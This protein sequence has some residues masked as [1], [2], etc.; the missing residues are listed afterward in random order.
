MKRLLF[1]LLLA[2]LPA[3]AA[4]FYLEP[5]VYAVGVWRSVVPQQITITLA[6]TPASDRRFL[7]GFPLSNTATP[8]L[9]LPPG[10]GAICSGGACNSAAFDVAAG[11]SCDIHYDSWPKDANGRIGVK[12]VGCGDLNTAG[13]ITSLANAVTWQSSQTGTGQEEG[14][15]CVQGSAGPGP[16]MWRG[17]DSFMSGNEFH[18]ADFRKGAVKKQMWFYRNRILPYW[19]AMWHPNNPEADGNAYG[20]RQQKYEC[21]GGTNMTFEGN[22]FGGNYNSSG[23]SVGEVMLMRNTNQDASEFLVMDNI[24]E[25]VAG[26]FLPGDTNARAP[27][28]WYG[29]P[30]VNFAAINNVSWDVNEKGPDTAGKGG[31]G[32]FSTPPGVTGSYADDSAIAA[33][34]GWLQQ[35]PTMHGGLVYLNNTFPDHRGRIATL[36]FVTRIRGGGWIWKNNFLPVTLDNLSDGIGARPGD[37]GIPDECNGLRGYKLLT[38]GNP[39]ASTFSQNVIL[40]RELTQATVSADG[41]GALNTIPSNPGDKTAIWPKYAV[42][43]WHSHLDPEMYRLPAGSIYEGKGADI[44]RLEDAMGYVRSVVA[45]FDAQ[46]NLVVSWYAPDEQPCTIDTAAPGQLYGTFSRD[47][48]DTAASRYRRVVVDKARF[49]AKT[50]YDVRLNC[51]RQSPVLTVQS[52]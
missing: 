31:A 45:A 4:V 48:S 15:Q 49:T 32:P 39:V 10:V 21:K 14:C 18:Q 24:F 30:N 50:P 35:G 25:H 27:G 44:T 40:S 28:V 33:G 37:D 17:N 13:T 46:N 23:T 26:F 1:A 20:I 2:T 41:W 29:P 3:S 22:L 36:A 52:N 5:G 34:Q 7:I 19:G 6:G 12:M 9:Y 8:T 47:Q 43:D 51:E 42:Q 38:C 11:G 16:L